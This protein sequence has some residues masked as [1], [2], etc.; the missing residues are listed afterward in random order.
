MQSIGRKVIF[1]LALVATLGGLGAALVGTPSVARAGSG[2]GGGGGGGQTQTVYNAKLQDRT[3]LSAHEQLDT[4]GCT[5]TAISLMAGEQVSRTLP[6]PTTTFG[7]VVVASISRWNAC[8]DTPLFIG[9]G[10]LRDV[11]LG[12]GNATSQV[13]LPATLVLPVYDRTTLGSTGG[14]GGGDTETPVFYATLTNVVWTATGPALHSVGNS[15]FHTQGMTSV[16]HYTGRSAPA[17]VS[18]TIT[19]GSYA[20]MGTA[21]LVHAEI[22]D[23]Q[24]GTL[25]IT[26]G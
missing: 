23:V 17:T 24:S 1:A 13:T 25:H 26:H 9:V 11:A 2:G 3:A 14:G 20:V 21:D 12:W 15:L 22:D 4:D 5:W 7:P 16:Q 19:V 6:G 8:T 18:G 10:E